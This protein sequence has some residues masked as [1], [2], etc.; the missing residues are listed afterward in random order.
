MNKKK[1][2]IVLAVILIIIVVAVILFLQRNKENIQINIEGLAEEISKSNAFEDQ[3][4]KIDSEMTMQDYNFSTDEIAQ[5]VSYQ[6][7]GASSEEIVILQ[8]KDKN[9]INSVKEKI[10]T[11]L[12]ERREAFES[13]LPEEVGKIDN[14]ILRVEGNYIIL[15]VANDAN[16]VNNVINEYIK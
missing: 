5:L 2:V 1:I 4:E 13:Y 16:T 10:N 8:V 14:S 9:Y 7:S 3:L 15:C 6:G 11:R 12:S